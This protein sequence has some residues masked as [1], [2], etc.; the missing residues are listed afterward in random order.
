METNLLMSMYYQVAVLPAIE[1][2]YA[3]LECVRIRRKLYD[4]S[5][6]KTSGR[7]EGG[8][9]IPRLTLDDFRQE[10]CVRLLSYP[11]KKGTT[12][13][14]SRIQRCYKAALKYTKEATGV[15]CR[16]LDYLVIQS[17]KNQV[18]SLCCHT[19][20]DLVILGVHSSC[21]GERD[22]EKLR[23]A[24]FLERQRTAAEEAA[25]Q[26]MDADLIAPGEL[27]YEEYWDEN[28]H[29]KVKRYG[30]YSVN[31][32][33]PC[34]A[35][36]AKKAH[37]YGIIAACRICGGGTAPDD[38]TNRQ[39]DHLFAICQSIPLS[40]YTLPNGRE[41]KNVGEML[42]ILFQGPLADTYKQVSYKGRP[43]NYAAAYRL[44]KNFIDRLRALLKA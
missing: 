30:A 44:Q 14:D 11:V 1:S 7:S 9:P 41:I 29:C 26:V 37:S 38:A 42:T 33:E 34:M 28:L 32:S 18:Y 39:L 12:S 2:C 3:H 20:R 23:K 24:Y 6:L 5:Y 31:E 22:A 40:D 15:H 8:K 13:K 27:P 21:C 10:V 36:A 35:E 4:F 17:V 25:Q 19:V 16:P 43:M